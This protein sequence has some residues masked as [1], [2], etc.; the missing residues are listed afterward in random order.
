MYAGG[1]AL[2][3]HVF[4]EIRVIDCGDL[5]FDPLTIDGMMVQLQQHAAQILAAS[6]KE[7]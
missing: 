3:F 1:A 7:N 4:D 5:C 2:D 6:R